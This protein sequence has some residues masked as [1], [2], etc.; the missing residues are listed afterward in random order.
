MGPK[1]YTTKNF[2]ISSI[3]SPYGPG[4]FPKKAKNR[5]SV[6]A[7]NCRILKMFHLTTELHIDPY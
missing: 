7:E 3:R 2:F 4:S 5:I 1:N 6:S